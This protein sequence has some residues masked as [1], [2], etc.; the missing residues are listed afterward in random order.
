VVAAELGDP[1]WAVDPRFLTNADHAANKDTIIGLISDIMRRQPSA[2]WQARL[3]AAGVP[4][5]PINDLSA[6]TGEPTC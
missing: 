6:A 4:C 3:D 2:N 5:A 1:E